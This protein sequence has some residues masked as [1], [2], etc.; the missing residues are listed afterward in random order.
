MTSHG[1]EHVQ[2]HEPTTHAAMDC[3][4]HHPP[5]PRLTWKQTF[6]RIRSD[7]AQLVR[8][9]AEHR[10]NPPHSARLHPGFICVALYRLSNHLYRARHPWVARMIWHMNLILTGADISEPANIDEGLV[11]PTPAGVAIMGTAGRNLTVMA[12]SGLG[13]ELGRREDI[14]AGPGLPIVGDDVIM[15]PHTGVLGPVRVGNRV[16]IRAGCVVTREV[17]DDSVLEPPRARFLARRNE[18]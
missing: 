5:L 3:P 12:C 7:H 13:G 8:L 14:G 10:S 6:A 9:L 11:V 17:A 4:A 15:E 1:V 16:R 18:S 2:H